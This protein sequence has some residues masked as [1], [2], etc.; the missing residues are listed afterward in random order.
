M[1]KSLVDYV[2]NNDYLV[3]IDSDGCVFDNM[4]VKH[5]KFF[6]PVL[7][8]TF[9]MEDADGS[10]AAL[11]NK[12]NLDYPTRGINR[13][14][15]LKM[16]F[17]SFKPTEDMTA[18]LKL[19]ESENGL[20]ND[21]IQKE[22]NVSS[23]P[24][25]TK[26]L[27]WSTNLNAKI[28]AELGT[29]K[30]F[31]GVVSAIEKIVKVADIVVVSSANHEAVSNEWDEAGLLPYV[32]FVS[33]QDIGPK[34]DVLKILQSKGYENSKMLMVGDAYG[35]Y[36]AAK[37]IGAHFYQITY[38]CEAQSWAQLSESVI[39]DF[40]NNN[41]QYNG[42]ELLDVAINDA[43]EVI[44]TN[45]DDYTDHFQHVSVDGVYPKEFNK[46]WTMSFYPGQLYL[47]QAITGE[48]SYVR[49]REAILGSFKK[50]CDEGHMATHDIG[51][52]FELTAY[53]DYLYCG[54]EASKALVIEA[55][56]KLMIRYNEAGGFIQAWGPVTEEEGEVRIII[57]CMMNLPL[58]HIASDLTGDSKY[59][60]AA[61][62]HAHVSSKTLS[63][64]D[65][66]TYHTYWMDNLSGKALRGATHQ[67]NRDESTWAR[68]QAWSVYGFYKS[69]ERTNEQA[70]LDAA[71]ISADQFIKNL[72]HNDICY[73][74]FDFDDG[75]PDIRDSSAA[76]IAASGL[77]KL[78]KVVPLPLG[79][80]YYQEGLKLIQI[81][82]NRYQNVDLHKGCGIL[83]EGMYHRDE[84]FN[85]YTSWGD[86]YYVEALSTL[87]NAN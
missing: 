40:L 24:L 65:G 30:P 16:F 26:V 79:E 23:D 39:N 59:K 18:F 60:E 66:T 67:G 62:S 17:E 73:W 46:L 81:L 44:K 68:G 71:I 80:H 50:R 53:Y 41:Y 75:K 51:F 48:D 5:Q 31:D 15:G 3:A 27:T 37:S 4:T 11:W 25:L 47:A 84:G 72:P 49:N 64:K 29:M 63:R 55:A 8:E 36:N 54:D 6:F 42:P 32:Q 69:F 21:L 10:K 7:L 14:E 33:S 38:K 34:A 85:E 78:S 87:I 77:I 58:L 86:Y 2:K 61:I 74:D 35:D 20:S 83:R 1:Y 45:I 52:L 19:F 57:D 43:L 76:S 22:I 12:I 13:F 82:S 9:N 56:D 28:K 70:F